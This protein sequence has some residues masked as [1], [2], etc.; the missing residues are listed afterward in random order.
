M[1]DEER[2]LIRN[3]EGEEFCLMK[4]GK[5]VW[6]YAASP[7]GQGG[8]VVFGGNARLRKIAKAILEAVGDE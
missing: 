3:S 6:F 4:R 2:L 8:S 7:Y 1:S 5:K